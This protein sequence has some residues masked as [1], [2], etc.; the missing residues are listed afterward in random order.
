MRRANHKMQEKNKNMQGNYI[1]T[2]TATATCDSFC[3]AGEKF[4][5]RKFDS[6]T[7]F[8][9]DVRIYIY[10]Y[11]KRYPMNSLMFQLSQLVTARI[12]HQ[13][14]QQSE[15]SKNSLD[16]THACQLATRASEAPFFPLSGWDVSKACHTKMRNID[17]MYPPWKRRFLLET[18]IFR[19][20]LLVSGRVNFILLNWN[21]GGSSNSAL[22]YE[23]TFAGLLDL[24]KRPSCCCSFFVPALICQDSRR[25]ISNH[26]W[27]RLDFWQTVHPGKASFNML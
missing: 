10:I 13:P 18:T 14:Y 11:H 12:V 23:M 7:S 4:A 25:N 24:L 19:G 8:H 27:Q 21:F 3:L 16:V 2:T 9:D 15:R 26:I 5:H 20:E 1:S 22:R 6:Y 17:D